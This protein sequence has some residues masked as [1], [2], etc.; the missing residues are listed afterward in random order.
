[1][2]RIHQA[3]LIGF[4][5]LGGL[6]PAHAQNLSQIAKVRHGGS[7][8]HCNLFQADM[9]YLKVE[10][11]NFIG[12]RL[13]QADLSGAVMPQT[14]FS[15][16]DLRDLNAYGAVLANSN[17]SHANLT[18]ASFVGAYLEGASFRGADLEGVNFAGADMKNVRGLTNTQLATACGDSAT[19]L[20]P[21]LHLKPCS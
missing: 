20:P 8:S 5:A 9:T 18:R 3:I 15:D 2:A 14:Q 12:A 21:G 6:I 17:F 13:R 10:A 1:M 4:I 7:C 16:A 11:R 19:R